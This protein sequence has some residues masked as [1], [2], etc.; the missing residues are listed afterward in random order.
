[1]PDTAIALT[2]ERLRGWESKEATR[3]VAALRRARIATL[4]GILLLIATAGTSFF[5]AKTGT[6]PTV[7]VNTGGDGYCGTLGGG[8]TEGTVTVTGRDGTVHTIAITD[9]T[10]I[11]NES[12]C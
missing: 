5:A 4:M 1:V 7:R 8:R 3:G 12:A 10:S 9:I 6:G 11:A 2:G